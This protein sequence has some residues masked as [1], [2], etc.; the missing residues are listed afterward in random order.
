MYPF[1]MVDAFNT[2]PAQLR[3]SPMLGKA[4][5]SRGRAIVS[6]LQFWK[7]SQDWTAHEAKLRAHGVLMVEGI[8]VFN[9]KQGMPAEV[10]FDSVGLVV[11]GG[12]APHHRAS[13]AAQCLSHQIPCAS[14]MFLYASRDEPPSYQ[15]TDKV[16]IQAW[17]A[18]ASSGYVVKAG[19][20]GVGGRSRC[21]SSE[22]VDCRGVHSDPSL[23]KVSI[24]TPAPS[25]VTYMGAKLSPS[26]YVESFL[27]S[28][29]DVLFCADGD[30][31]LSCSCL[32]P[33]I[34]APASSS[35]SL[36]RLKD[37]PSLMPGRY[38]WKFGSIV[39]YQWLLDQC[40]VE[41]APEGSFAHELQKLS[42]LE[43]VFR[44]S[45]KQLELIADTWAESWPSRKRQ[46]TKDIS[47]GS[48]P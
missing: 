9:V 27:S 8:N 32:L 45:D 13:A 14:L 4:M 11:V 29:R 36:Q 42:D 20:D 23:V 17:T 21:W 2:R 41:D 44:K 47:T 40:D 38:H 19:R 35:D 18:D 5:S 46:R 7:S 12:F 34:T 10:Q 3:P 26:M 25:Q 22:S 15:D 37:L 1:L 6:D 48:R 16:H 24:F 28:N 39:S 43:N 33:S 31:S 30:A